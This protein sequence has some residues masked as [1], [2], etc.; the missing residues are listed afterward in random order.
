MHIRAYITCHAV[1]LTKNNNKTKDFIFFLQLDEDLR[2]L[3]PNNPPFLPFL[4][5]RI[6][7]IRVHPRR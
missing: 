5:Q 7:L 6:T 3:T 1:K 2:G 4:K